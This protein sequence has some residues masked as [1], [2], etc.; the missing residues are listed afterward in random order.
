MQ[1]NNNIRQYRKEKGISQENMAD[2]LGMTQPNYSK[3]EKNF[4]DAPLLLRIATTLK[5][6]PDALSYYHLPAMPI[7]TEQTQALLQQKDEMISL[8][9]EQLNHVRAEN[10]RLHARLADCLQGGK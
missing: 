2:L 8:L 7:A 1:L 4:I 5:T 6:T 10:S 3:V 9:K